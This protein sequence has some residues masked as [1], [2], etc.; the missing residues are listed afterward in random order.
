MRHRWK[1]TG[2]DITVTIGCA[3]LALLT[4]G[5]AGESARRLARELVC[6][7]NT[8]VLTE[9]WLA[10]A[11]DNDGELVGGSTS[12]HAGRMSWVDMPTFTGT[13]DEKLEAIRQGALFP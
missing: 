7:G 11:D 6:L 8:E 5:A 13:L 2:A 4:L 1:M 10:Y 12:T 9:A 3:V